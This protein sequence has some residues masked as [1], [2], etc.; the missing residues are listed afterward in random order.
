[1]NYREHITQKF[2]TLKSLIKHYG[3]DGVYILCVNE[4]INKT[5]RSDYNRKRNENI[6]RIR[7]E[8]RVYREKYGKLD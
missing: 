6:K 3:K 2:P 8:V 1:M 7:E 5:R 4:L